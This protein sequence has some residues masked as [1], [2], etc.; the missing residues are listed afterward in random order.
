MTIND[1]REQNAILLEC[2][3]GSKAYGLDTPASDTDIKGVFIA[4]QADLYGLGY[5]PQISNESNDVVFYE[6]GRFIE[7]L[8]KNNPAVLELLFTPK[9]SIIYRHPIMK[10]LEPVQFLS[11]LCQKTF[12][13]YA[14]SQIK[15][16]KG[17]HK[18]I[19]NPVDK[20]RKSV[21]DFC[22]VWQR[23][24][25]INLKQWLDK[26]QVKQENCGLTKVPHMKDMYEIYHDNSGSYKGIIT[27][28]NAN[29]VSL[30][31]IN[32]D[33]QPLAIMSFNKDGYSSYCRDYHAYWQWVDN[34]NE[35]R[36]QNTLQHGKNYDAKN[37]MHTFRLLHTAAEIGE[38]G[39]VKVKRPDRKFLLA[40][41]SGNF[42]YE[43][44]V[45]KAEEKIKLIGKI[46]EKSSLP[47]EPDKRKA[48]QLVV[49]MRKAYYQTI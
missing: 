48:N 49:Q 27:N 25:S 32:I 47:D 22:Y 20:K 8:L 43:E 29:E 14:M 37:M 36:Y 26:Q 11:K 17:L 33:E 34:R 21:L 13:G 2:I 12:A 31:S 28:E 35:D 30:S 9:D 15:K 4:S 1:L 10:M 41:K 7:L 39:E 16:A 40:I 19:L 44:L 45:A 5:I 23:N 42:R 38:E 6:L 24:G 46:Y 3:S 18:K